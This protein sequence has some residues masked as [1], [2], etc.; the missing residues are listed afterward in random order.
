MKQ[1]LL[2]LSLLTLCVIP[3]TSCETGNEEK[4]TRLDK[5]L[6]SIKEANHD[7]RVHEVVSVIHPYEENN[8]DIRSEITLNYTYRYEGEKRSHSREQIVYSYD[9]DKLT[10]LA[11][12]RTERTTKVPYVSYYKNI[13]TGLAEVRQI[14]LQN[15]LEISTL[16]SQ[17]SEGSFIPIIYDNEFS[18]PFDFITTRDLTILDNGDVSLSKSK[19]NFLLDAYKTIGVNMVGSATI[20]VNDNDQITKI[21]FEIPEL[22]GESYIRHNVISIEYFNHD[23]AKYEDLK[24]FENNNPE[25][26]EALTKYKDVKNFTYIKDYLDTNGE[27]FDRI[28]GFY[29]EDTVYFHHGEATDTEPYKKG[30]N[31]DYKAVKHEDGLYYIYQYNFVSV[32]YHDWGIVYLT[33]TTPYTFDSF[34]AMAPRYF[35]IS[36]SIFKK[37]GDKK[38]EV[39]PI[40]LHS[41]GQYFDYG[42]WGVHTSLL[43]STTTSLVI[44][45]NDKNEI[46]LIETGFFFENKT[47]NINFHYA[48]INSTSI[49]SWMND[50]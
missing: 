8:V 32:D 46:E 49:P 18:N 28:T 2:I 7:V 19:A 26:H 22:E 44:T 45:L 13:E 1:K 42:V 31:Y 20:K 11:D 37:I 5:I 17:D 41:I 48:N 14:N 29:T 50:N 36:S 39:E 30:D 3:L 38:Y 35:N 43:N 24:P 23:T 47:T 6:Y 12:P 21:D 16:V 25:L 27:I 10:G 40:F 33:G 15:E 9:I 34:E 4:P